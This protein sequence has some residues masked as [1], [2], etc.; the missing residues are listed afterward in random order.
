MTLADRQ[1]KSGKAGIFDVKKKKNAEEKF[2]S[3]KW[4]QDDYITNK[5]CEE[6]H[7]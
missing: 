6:Y 7:V 2:F 4:K 1:V 5:L 3:S